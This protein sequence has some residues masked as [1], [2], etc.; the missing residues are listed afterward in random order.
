M[1]AIH[2]LH[3]IKVR[4]A[5]EH[6]RPQPRQQS[7]LSQQPNKEPCHNNKKERR[8]LVIKTKER[9]EISNKDNIQAEMTPTILDQTVLRRVD[10]AALG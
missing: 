10:I 3:Q 6:L 5:A 1:A 4:V 8:T 2:R 9:T 7:P